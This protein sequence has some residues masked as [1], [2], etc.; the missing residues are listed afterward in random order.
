MEYQTNELHIDLPEVAQ[1]RT[2]N[3]LTI[4]DPAQNSTFQIILNRDALVGGETLPQCV[5]RQIGLIKRQA[6]SFKIVDR[7]ACKVGPQQIDAITLES[8]F[9]QSGKTFHQLQALFITQAPTLMAVTLSSH[10]PLHDGHRK[11]WADL[12]AGLSL[13]DGVVANDPVQ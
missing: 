9:T 3:V 13:R 12:L 1:D 8:G 6:Q 2:I 5:E 11:A 4:P 7:Q 10:Q